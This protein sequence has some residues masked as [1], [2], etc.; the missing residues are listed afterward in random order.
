[1]N[2][3]FFRSFLLLDKHEDDSIGW[4][5]HLAAMLQLRHAVMTVVLP[6]APGNTGSWGMTQPTV[7]TPSVS[8]SLK[9]AADRGAG[10]DPAELKSNVYVSYRNQGWAPFV[11]LDS[12]DTDES[13]EAEQTELP[14]E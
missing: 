14:A 12:V 7:Q 5:I 10:P 6:Y 4:N 11:V 3:D 1:L 13:G 2:K 9:F 8:A